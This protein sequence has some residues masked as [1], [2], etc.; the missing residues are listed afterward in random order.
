MALRTTPTVL[1]KRRSV[2]L[3]IVLSVV[4]GVAATS[5]FLNIYGLVE[6]ALRVQIE[7]VTGFLILAVIGNI[8][9]YWVATG[10]NTRLES[11]LRR[12][13]SGAEGASTAVDED[14]APA[15]TSLGAAIHEYNSDL[16]RSRALKTARIQVQR[17]L[18]RVVLRATVGRLLILSG[19]GTVLYMSA[20]AAAEYEGK[21]SSIA[22]HLEPTG[23]AVAARLLAG[24]GPGIVHVDGR[25]MHYLGVF[26]DM[27]RTGTGAS[28]GATGA[29]LAY[30]VIAENAVTAGPTTVPST[31]RRTT[32]TLQTRFVRSFPKNSRF[33]L[34]PARR[35]SFGLGFDIIFDFVAVHVGIC[36]GGNLLIL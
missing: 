11:E 23:S 32:N 4:V 35:F 31:P 6:G 22:P 8:A 21:N 25:Q 24:N 16:N 30:I 29:T 19:A 7:F 5:L 9:A 1:L 15:L 28:D 10:R 17:Q 13:R 14:A 3:W 12:S 34:L 36:R 20:A 27:V 18:L 33:R 26:G 2:R